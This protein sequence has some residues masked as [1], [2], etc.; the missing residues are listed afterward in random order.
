MSSPFGFFSGVHTFSLRLPL[1][2]IAL[3]RHLGNIHCAH[4]KHR[5]LFL[6]FGP[7]FQ[8]ARCMFFTEL[9]PEANIRDVLQSFDSRILFQGRVVSPQ[10][11]YCATTPLILAWKYGQQ[12]WLLTA[13]L[14]STSKSSLH[15]IVIL[16]FAI[17]LCCVFARPASNRLTR[18]SSSSLS[19]RVHMSNGITRCKPWRHLGVLLAPRA[20]ASTC[21]RA[22]PAAKEVP[23]LL[24]G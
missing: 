4:F 5:I 17:F 20:T 8:W 12:L 13:G 15:L 2:L 19:S 9:V 10:T 6:P 7:N 1:A 11:A 22:R 24:P 16:I 23:P 14:S 3:A 21:G 18:S